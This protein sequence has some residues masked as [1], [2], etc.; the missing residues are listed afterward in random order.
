MRLIADCKAKKIDFVITK[1]ISRFSRN[2]TDCLEIVRTLLNLNI[3]IY[4]EKK[5]IN[6]M[7]AKDEVLITIMASLAQQESQSLSQNVKLGLQFR[8]Q[9]G[10]VQVNHNHFLGY[11]K[12]ENGNLIIDPEQAEVVK[13]IYREYLEGYSMDKIAK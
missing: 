12:D 5:S 9:N 11:T 4:F 3:P 6:T 10:Q 8:Y 1:S 2:T 7:D 13:R